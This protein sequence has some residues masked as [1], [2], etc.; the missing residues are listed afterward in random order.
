MDGTITEAC[1]IVHFGKRLI[2]SGGTNH[3]GGIKKAVFTAMT[4]LLHH[5]RVMAM[6]CA[7]SIGSEDDVALLFGL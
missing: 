3:A 5:A 1:V 7:A 6:H 4:Y 2:L